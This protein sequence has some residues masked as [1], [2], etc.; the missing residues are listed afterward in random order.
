VSDSRNTGV[1][2]A[3]A[4]ERPPLPIEQDQEAWLWTIGGGEA[5]P[6]RKHELLTE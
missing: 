6:L 1:V 2:H 4:V 3:I 5:G